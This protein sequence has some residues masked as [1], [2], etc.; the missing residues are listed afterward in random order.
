MQQKKSDESNTS[1]PKKRRCLIKGY[2][3]EALPAR[4]VLPLD[5][6]SSLSL[7]DKPKD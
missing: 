7:P 1:K 5:L 4:P 6:A 2:Q 3:P